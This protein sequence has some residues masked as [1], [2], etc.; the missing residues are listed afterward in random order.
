MI[1]TGKRAAY[2]TL[3]CKL[4]FS[5]TST[6]RRSLEE[7][8][9]ISVNEKEG[10]DI[11]VINTCSVTEVAERKARQLIRKIIKH[12]PEAYIVVVGC[13]A[14]LGA[15]ELMKI[16]GVK[17]VL[18]ADEK[19]RVAHYLEHY[20]ELQ[21][22][23][24]H[25]CNVFKLSNFDLA[26]SFGDRTRSFLKIQDGCD[27]FCTY[28]TIPFA[29][30]K[31]RSASI[32]EVV[33]TAKE[34]SHKGIREIILTGVNTGDFGRDSDENF[35]QLIQSLDQVEEIDRFR[36]SSIEPNLLTDEIISFIASSKRFMP[37]FHIPLQSG[38]NQ[39][40][41]L[42]KRRYNR[43]LF[44]DKIEKINTICPDTFIGVDIIAGMRGEKPED[45]EDARDFVEKLNVSQ[46][47]VFPYSERQGTKALEI[48]HIVSQEEKHRRVEVLLRISETKL[49]DF[50]KRFEGQTREVLF[51]ENKVKGRIYGFTDNYIRVALPYD[52]NLANRIIP[53]ELKPEILVME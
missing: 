14:Q 33:N 51:E 21:K 49:H 9:T 7:A 27:Y 2:I 25:S 42:M 50:Y 28:C 30:G 17:L 13:Y 39:V 15:Q 35:L 18:G 6:I 1:L 20:E 48:E 52:D 53:V 26:C 37:H 8:G 10:A 44:A 38:S 16:E 32:S 34:I 23:E 45:F 3:G 12:N 31:S 19:F 40:L 11:F 47:H 41:Q 4:N 5:E 29:R 36:I 46:L 43:E 24:P 22:Q